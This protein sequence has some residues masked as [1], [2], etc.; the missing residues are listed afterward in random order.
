MKRHPFTLIELMIG[1]IISGILLA[2][3]MGVFSQVTSLRDKQETLRE[4][5]LLKQH[6]LDTLQRDLANLAVPGGTFV[7]PFAVETHDAGDTHAD[8]LTYVTATNPQGTDAQLGGELL[9]VELRIDEDESGKQVL[10]R[11]AQANINAQDVDLPP[12]VVLLEDVTSFACRT[13]ASSD[14]QDGWTPV[15]TNDVP[16]AIELK[17]VAAGQAYR[18]V[19][20]PWA[21]T[22][23]T[24]STT[25]TTG[26]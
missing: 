17:I 21:G 9:R 1:L 7:T 19:V 11:S 4:Q 12:D 5:R 22:V 8:I 13:Y 24:T 15:N 10:V 3:L 16:V 25:T 18:L 2:G 23:A 26:N 14:W 6:C 20:A